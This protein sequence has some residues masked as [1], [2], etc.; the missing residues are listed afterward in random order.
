MFEIVHQRGEV[1]QF[2]VNF[3][4]Q[5][6]QKVVKTFENTFFWLETRSLS[7]IGT[8]FRALL[9]WKLVAVGP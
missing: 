4:P 2:L 9:K 7:F 5:K 6:S 3:E 1:T 8:G